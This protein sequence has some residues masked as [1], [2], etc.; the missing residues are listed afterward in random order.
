MVFLIYFAIFLLLVSTELIYFRIAKKLNI[1]DKPNIRSSHTHLTLRGGGIIF[2]IGVYVWSALYGLQYPWFLL[3][4]TFI[5]GIS[6][7]DDVRTLS[8]RI[9]LACQCL[10]MFLMFY[11]LGILSWQYWWVLTIALILCVGII[12]AYNFMDGIN[13]MTGVYSLSVILPLLFINM[14]LQFIDA[15]LLIIVG[16]STIV[17][18]FYN[19]RKRAKCFAGD[20]GA[21]AMAFIL[22]FAISKLIIQTKDFSYILLLAIYGVDTVLTIC[23]RILLH[24]NLGNAHRKHCYQLMA[25]ELKIPHIIVALMYLVMQVIV[26]FG[27]IVIPINHWLYFIIVIAL[28]SGIYILFI[29]KYYSLHQDYIDVMNE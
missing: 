2:L 23:H 15:N 24:E 12:N 22:L 14:D 13:G 6:F 19:C 3:G 26:S 7:I 1:I 16:L 8:Y 4:L 25:N 28:L 20:V 5:A 21:V 11:E 18:C 9:R 27:L 17:F 29:K 10:S